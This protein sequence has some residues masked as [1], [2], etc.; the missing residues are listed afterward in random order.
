M[1]HTLA[2]NLVHCVFSTKGRADLILD[3]ER[4]RQ[5]LTGIARAKSLHCSRLEARAITFMYCLLCRRRCR[6]R[7]QS[8]FSK[9]ILRV[10]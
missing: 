3:P 7:R 6:W 8:R 1:P 4:L 9:G 2:C 10:G 5:D